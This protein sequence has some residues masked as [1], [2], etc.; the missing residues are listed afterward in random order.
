MQTSIVKP[1][2][3][4]EMEDE[5]RKCGIPPAAR[6]FLERHWPARDILGRA[7]RGIEEDDNG[8]EDNNEAGISMRLKANWRSK[9]WWS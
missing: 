1:V 2:E 9:R 6:R 7:D 3:D 8:N 4:E 5:Q